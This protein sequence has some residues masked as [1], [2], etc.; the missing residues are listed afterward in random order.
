M[1]RESYN[2]KNWKPLKYKALQ[3]S[4]RSKWRKANVFNWC[5]KKWHCGETGKQP[6]TG[7]S[8]SGLLQL[9]W[10]SLLQVPVSFLL[11]EAQWKG[12][13]KASAHGRRCSF[14]RHFNPKL[15]MA[16]EVNN[17]HTLNWGQK[18]AGSHCS[19]MASHH[20]SQLV[21]WWFCFGSGMSLCLIV[22]SDT[23]SP[24]APQSTGLF[25]LYLSCTTY[26]LGR[27]EG[28]SMWKCTCIIL[29]FLCAIFLLCFF[30]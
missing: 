19:W 18:L 3:F 27:R 14:F 22:S 9:T 25:F 20:R 8:V 4:G 17:I 13:P 23:L 15:F 2:S 24:P 10:L 11:A 28:L 21:S 30:F 5:W 1:I 6:W 16:L 29:L 7:H 12:F 26:R